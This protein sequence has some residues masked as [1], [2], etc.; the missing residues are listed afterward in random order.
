VRALSSNIGLGRLS[1]SR[2]GAGAARATERKMGRSLKSCMVKSVLG[3]ILAL[4]MD[5][6]FIGEA[7]RQYFC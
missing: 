3:K 1:A 4:R 7:L 5:I 6:L 2:S